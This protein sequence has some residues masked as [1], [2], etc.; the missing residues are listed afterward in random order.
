MLPGGYRRVFE[1][2]HADGHFGLLAGLHRD[3]HSLFYT[4]YRGI[5]KTADDVYGKLPVY[6]DHVLSE[7]RRAVV[8]QTF[9]VVPVA[10]IVHRHGAKPYPVFFVI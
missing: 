5:R 6:V 1:A 8:V 3:R 2:P 4:A 10:R 9:M 7:K